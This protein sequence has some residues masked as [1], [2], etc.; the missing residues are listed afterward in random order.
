MERESF[1]NEDIA[2]LMNEHYI[3]IKVDREQLPDV[4]ALYMSAVMLVNGNGGWPMSSFLD[5]KGRTFYGA[6]Y[7]PPDQFAQI[8]QRIETLWREQRPALMDQA[9][10]ITNAVNLN[11]QTSSEAIDVGFRE[12]SRGL[13][14]AQEGF[15]RIKGGFGGAPKF[16]RESTLY[17]LLDQAMRSLPD[18]LED[19]YSSLSMADNTLQKMAA[20]GI[21]DHVGGG[22]HRYAVDS[23]WLVPHFEKMLY[24][25]A[26]LARN[27]S[28][29][30]QLTGNEDHQRTAE[31]I[32]DY[33]LRDMTS[34]N[35]MFYSATDADSEG[36]EGLFF[37]WNP[38]ELTELLGE[39]DGSIAAELWKVTGEG[40]FEGTSILHTPE[41][42]ESVAA[43]FDMSANQLIEKVDQWTET[44]RAAREL[45]EHP[46]R[47]EKM[48]GSWNGMMIS[49]LAKGTD[50]LGSERYLD[51]AITAAESLWTNLKKPDGTL[52]RIYYNGQ[53][54]I[55]A[56]QADYAY[57]SEAFVALYDATANAIWLERA[58][59]LIS[60]MNTKFWDQDNGAYFMGAPSVA[61]T[62]LSTRPKDLHDSSIPSGNSVALRVLAQ[63]HK[64]TGDAKYE[65]NANKLIAALSS[66]L[67]QQPS[68][69][70]YL[71]TGVSEH[72]GGEAGALQYAGR[73]VVRAKASKR[74]DEL[75]V[76]IKLSDGWH[77]NSDAPLQDYLIP[78]QLNNVAGRPLAD[79]AYP[80]SKTRT[81]G[82][83]RSALSLFEDSF[84]LTAQWPGHEDSNSVVV[85]LQLQ[86]CND[87]IC[88]AP[89]TL[90]LTLYY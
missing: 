14:S 44:M 86:A 39:K 72:L 68:G 30:Y 45:R 24:N 38:E 3:S 40:N 60:I 16:P 18:Q 13:Q 54:S 22:F 35:G 5:V 88:L 15:D 1:E 77:I 56:T 28:Q 25:Q 66:R 21:H 10:Q 67:S 26:A 81:L 62:S 12:I 90:P 51:A 52:Y 17:F 83:Q 82:F 27:Y 71:L 76:S 2:G 48:I 65:T 41:S 89:E 50:R 37:V 6:T 63:L 84:E 70:Y 75:V 9:A 85:N 32:L 61:G 80:E 36:E 58:E 8:L 43:Q 46:L 19:D 78:T 29:A 47:D 49:A 42:I 7:F 31:R 20:G 79:V 11:S 33:V 74:D 23:Q 53:T 64:R 73:G 4:D 69:H 34:E 55:D 87:E 57:I 59:S